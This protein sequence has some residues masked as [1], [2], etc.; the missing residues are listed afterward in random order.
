MCNSAFKF[1]ILLLSCFFVISCKGQKNTNC[2]NALE[3]KLSPKINEENRIGEVINIR[4]NVNCFEWDSLIV[5]M[6]IALNEKAEKDLGIKLPLE[7]DYSWGSDSTAML[8]FIKDKKVV[9]HILQEATVD[10]KTFDAAKSIKTYHFLNLLKSY[11]SD[12]YYTIIPKKK[13]VF[14][15]YPIVYHDENGKEISNPKYGLGIK[16]KGN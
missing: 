4:D 13:T 11:G 14:E 6:A 2:I 10:K 8:L 3:E 5:I 12:S 15:T 9:H 16:V 7:H 1:I